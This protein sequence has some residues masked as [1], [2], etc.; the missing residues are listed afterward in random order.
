MAG[1]A[2]IKLRSNLNEWLNEIAFLTSAMS[3]PSEPQTFQQAWWHPDLET[4]EKWCDGTRLE[5]NKMNS[6]GVWRKVGSTSIPNGR[7]LVGCHWV[8]KIKHNG[9]YQARLVAKGFSQIPGLDFTDNFS[10]VV[11]DVTFRVVLTQ[12]I[13]EKWDVKIVDIDNAFLNGDL[14]HEII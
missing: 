1:F 10:P 2:D 8:F 7:R 6:M 3:D 14:V 4:R 5:F 12:M 13:I 9:V 11:N